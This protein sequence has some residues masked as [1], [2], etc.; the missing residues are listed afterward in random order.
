[1]RGVHVPSNLSSLHRGDKLRGSWAG[2]QELVQHT[3]LQGFW[4]VEA[5]LQSLL[6]VT[7]LKLQRAFRSQ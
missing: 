7:A 6:R 5:C 1:M 4:E 3:I 2:A